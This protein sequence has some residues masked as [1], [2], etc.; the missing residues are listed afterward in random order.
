MDGSFYIGNTSNLAERL[1]FH[2]SPTLN[3][4]I[5]RR[6]IPWHY[7]YILQVDNALVAG[8]IE[9]HI[10]RMK[11]KNYIINLKNYSETGERLIKKYS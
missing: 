3:I 1:I 7:Y 8:K 11:S 4:G 10:K 5:T 6:K 2:N 9:N